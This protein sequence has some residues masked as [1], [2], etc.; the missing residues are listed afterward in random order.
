M[1]ERPNGVDSTDPTSNNGPTDTAGISHLIDCL[2]LIYTETIALCRTLTDEQIA[3]PT[4]CPGWS[5]QDQLAHMVGFEQTLAGSPEPTVE[6]GDLAH[7]QNDIGRYMETHVEAR[8]ALP[9]AALIDEMVGLRPRRI[10]QLRLQASGGDSLVTMPWGAVRTLSEAVKVRVM[11]L[12][13]H[14]QDIRLAVDA[15]PRTDGPDGDLAAARTLAAWRAILPTSV[16]GPGVV[17]IGFTDGDRSRAVINLDPNGNSD[18]EP[19]LAI[20]G[21][22]SVLTRIGCGR[23][24]M[25]DHL[26]LAT[27]TGDDDLRRRVLPHLAFTP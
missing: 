9:F 3:R 27:I 16:E 19:Q 11:D 14:E 23:Q 6:L 25:S 24:P 21:T 7:V 12:W 13:S 26:A 8:R 22:R 15:P 2:D 10:A 1:P 17:R 20:S 18:K 5:V 4:G